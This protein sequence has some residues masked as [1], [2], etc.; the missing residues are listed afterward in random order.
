VNTCELHMPVLAGKST[1]RR[2]FGASTL[3]LIGL[4]V[5]SLSAS[6]ASASAV[7][8]I[9]GPLSPDHASPGAANLTMKVNGTGFASDAVVYWNGVALTTTFVSQAQVTATVPAADLA[10]AGTGQVTVANGSGIPSNVAYFQVVKSGYTVAFSKLDYATDDT[11]QD[12]TAGDFNG[13]GQ[14][15]L[16]VATGSNTVDVFLGSGNGTFPT[17]TSYGVPGNPVAIINGDFTGNGILD[18]ATADQYLSEVSVLLGNGDGTFQP[19]QEYATGAKPVALATADLTGD[20]I[21]DIVT[22]NQ[23]A[24]TVSVLLGNGNGTFQTHVDYATGNGPMSV[25]IGDFNGDGILDLA[26]ANN[27]DGTVSI[28]LGAGNGTFGAPTA[29]STAS[30][31]TSVVAGDFGSNGILDLAVATSNKTLSVLLGNG[32]G[33]FQNPKNN[34]IGADAEEVVTGDLNASGDLSLI[35]ANYNDNTVSTLVGSGNGAFKTESVF[36]TNLAPTG[37]AIGDFNDDGKLDIAAVDS[38]AN[39]VSILLDS[40]ITLSP[41]L[42]AFGTETS[43]DPSGAKSI[44]VKNNGTTA[45][46]LGSLSFTGAYNSDFTA[47]SNNCPAAGTNLA[48]GASCTIDIVFDPTASESADAQMILTSSNGSELGAQFTGQ[49]NIPVTLS[50]RTMT[51]TWQLVGTKSMGKTDTFTNMSGVDVYFTSIALTGTNSNQFSS[52]T[53]CPDNNNV[54]LAPGASCTSTVYFVPTVSGDAGT[55]QVY[56]GNFTQVEQGLLI[57]G[58][59]TAVKVTPTSLKLNTNAGGTASGNV[60]FQNAGSVPLA[61]SSISFNGTA[62]I[63]SET[64]TCNYPNGSVPATSS[65]TITVSCSPTVDGTNTATMSIGSSDPDAPE[66]VSIT[67]TATD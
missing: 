62:N 9:N 5:L 37:L 31:P 33:T 43:G 53:T 28:L 17:Y 38:S 44:V 32:N 49:G 26:V 11:P 14:I 2:L 52:T 6:M 30:N 40:W 4:L 16:A 56:T 55:A 46:D 25:A 50:P 48:A 36:P 12:V 7:P 65:C 57:S 13:N 60:T 24:N 3:T 54:P 63:F 41:S 47:S 20:G 67:C 29:F 39:V 1:L 42:V 45:Y 19:H 10:T 22:V 58:E 35:T 64:N 51:F 27:I 59:A 15:S 18:L 61:I 34:A 8:V 21:L 66:S 23:S